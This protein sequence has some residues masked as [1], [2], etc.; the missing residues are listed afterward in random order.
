[1][2]MSHPDILAVVKWPLHVDFAGRLRCHGCMSIIELDKGLAITV[3][4]VFLA[5]TSH[6]ALHHNAH[7]V[8]L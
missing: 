6:I 3:D 8:E 7:P 1:M 2:S 4:D 5:V